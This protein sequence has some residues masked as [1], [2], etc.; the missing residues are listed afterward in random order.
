MP[1]PANGA[2]HAPEP[3]SVRQRTGGTGPRTLLLHGLA[4]NDTVWDHCL[5]LLPPGHQIWTAK[6]PWRADGPQDWPAGPEPA[7]WLREALDA[8]GGAE[9]V[10]AHSMSTTILLDLLNRTGEPADDPCTQ[11]GIRR[12]V[13]VS[14][15][16]RRTTA[17]FDWTTIT[18]YLNDFHLIMEEG[19]RAH[20][21]GHFPPDT[22]RAMALRVRD[23]VGPHGWLRFFESYL[24]TPRL[25]T[26]RVTAPCLVLTGTDDFAAP[27][28]EGEVLADVL[29]DARLEHLPDAGHFP[30]IEQPERFASQIRV[31]LE[32]PAASPT[33][34]AAGTLTL[35]EPKR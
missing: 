31:F 1:A 11:L 25:R 15:F 10:V 27:P 33:A 21:V 3:V 32:P 26:G 17:E 4:A 9:V 22:Q 29:P 14:P 2:A 13:L 35:P 8:V 16:Y 24:R 6:L 23:R 7:E 30:M 5:P 12:L 28:A 20:S 19:I 34:P 18:H